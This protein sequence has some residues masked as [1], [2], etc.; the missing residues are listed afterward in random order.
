MY[1]GLVPRR[2]TT[3]NAHEGCGWMNGGGG[4]GAVL[5][6]KRLPPD[7]LNGNALRFQHA[8]L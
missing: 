8:M 4:P 6:K 5:G 2:G 7:A 1:V 3:V